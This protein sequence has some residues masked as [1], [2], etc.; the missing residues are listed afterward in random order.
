MKFLL[1]IK[2]VISIIRNLRS[3]INDIVVYNRKVLMIDLLNK[4][5]IRKGISSEPFETILGGAFFCYS[6]TNIVWETGSSVLS[7]YRKYNA[8][9]CSS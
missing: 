7:Y 8:E 3:F 9:Y 6:I 4:Q 5:T 2:E 1:L